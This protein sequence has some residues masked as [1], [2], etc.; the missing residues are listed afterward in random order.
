MYENNEKSRQ[1]SFLEAEIPIPGGKT[2]LVDAEFVEK[3]QQHKWYYR[4]NKS[5][6]ARWVGTYLTNGSEVTLPHF[7]LNLAGIDRNGHSLRPNDGDHTNCKLENWWPQTRTLGYV[8]PEGDGY[9]VPLPGGQEALV[10]EK[11][12]EQ[13]S[14]YRWRFRDHRKAGT[15]YVWTRIQSRDVMLHRFVLGLAGVDVRRIALRPKNGN[16]ADCRLENWA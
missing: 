2:I 5:N 7:I 12:A 3:V 15:Q 14:Q 11:F 1:L 16:H 9:R 6:G 13:V 4:H 8:R 10:D